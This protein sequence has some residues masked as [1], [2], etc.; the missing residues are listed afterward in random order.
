MSDTDGKSTL[1]DAQR[2][3][4]EKNRQRALLLRQAR[5]SSRPYPQTKPTDRA[6]KVTSLGR[7]I[8]TG[9]GFLLEDEP[10]EE[11]SGQAKIVHEPG[12]LLGGAPLTCVECTK[13]FQ[14]SYIYAHFE[15]EVCDECKDTEDKHSLIAKTDAKQLYLLKD[16]DLDR[17]EPALKFIVRKN[18]HNP[19]WGEM[20][21]YLALQVEK[22]ALEIWGS[23]EKIEEAREER[24][25][26][27]EKAKQKKFD[28]KVQNLRRAVRSSLWTK[29]TQSHTHTYGPEAYDEDSDMYSKTC[30][31]C[32]HTLSYEKM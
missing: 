22:R 16:A 32:K 2:A 23:S 6:E 26:N 30:T 8:D 5:L 29:D 7:V 11:Q 20:K 19:R 28:K 13:G 21:L 25:A 9:A 10:E 15:Y 14:D 3:K 27:K 1:S 17:R 31:S 24:E 4:I 18:P 12:P